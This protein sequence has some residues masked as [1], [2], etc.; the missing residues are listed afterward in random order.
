MGKG[1]PPILTINEESPDYINSRW[2]Y[3][4]PGVVHDES[5]LN[6][7]TTEELLLTLPKKMITP[8]TFLIKPLMSLFLAGVGRMDFLKG[9]DSIRITVYASA[10]LPIMIVKTDEADCVYNE[11]LGT[12]LMRVPTGDEERLNSWPGLT[13]SD[14]FTV[15]GEGTKVSACGECWKFENC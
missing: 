14:I 1:V 9:L 3:D 2:C 7:L 8:R 5:I 11:L 13:C 4:T 6:L 10:E 12:E 15:K